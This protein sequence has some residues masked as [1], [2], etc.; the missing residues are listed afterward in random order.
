MKYITPFPPPWKLGEFVS[1]ADPRKK[2]LMVATGA[3]EI[4][5]YGAHRDFIRWVAESAPRE[6]DYGA[7]IAAGWSRFKYAQ[8]TRE[9]I[10]FKRGA[11]YALEGLA[12]PS[13]QGTLD[14]GA[15][16]VGPASFQRAE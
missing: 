4:A 11:E 2:V 16:P 8:G 15:S 12:E 5:E 10:A 3:S 9:C 7:L 1:S 6:L 14:S 13:A